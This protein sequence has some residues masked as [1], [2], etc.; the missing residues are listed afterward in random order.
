MNALFGD[1]LKKKW[2]VAIAIPPTWNIPPR[3]PSHS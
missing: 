1:S 3:S 2:H